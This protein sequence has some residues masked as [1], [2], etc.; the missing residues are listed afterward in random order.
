MRPITLGR[1]FDLITVYIN[2]YQ[3]IYH[4]LLFL[5]PL[6]I[7]NISFVSLLDFFDDLCY[8]DITLLKQAKFSK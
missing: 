1:F 7:Q 6:L 3:P 8:N 5:L 4:F 2:L